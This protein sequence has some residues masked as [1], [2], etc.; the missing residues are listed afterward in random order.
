M[1]FCR[2]ADLVHGLDGRLDGCGKADRE[3][4]ADQIIVDRSGAAHDLSRTNAAPEPPHRERSRRRQ[5]ESGRRFRASRE[6][7]RLSSVP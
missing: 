6:S 7:T 2:V 5:W 3:V 4:R 1:A